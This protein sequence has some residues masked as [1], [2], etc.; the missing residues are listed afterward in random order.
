MFFSFQVLKEARHLLPALPAIGVV[1]AVLLIHAWRPLSR[2][3]RL[4][5]ITVGFAFPGYLFAAYSF[6]TPYVPR[7]DLQL[8]PFTVMKRDL[9]LASLQLMPTYT[10]PANPVYW[11]TREIIAVIAADA[12]NRAGRFPSVRAVGEHPYLSGLNLVYQSNLD[13]TPIFSHGPFVHEDPARFSYSVVIC[14]PEKRYGP[15]DV[16]EPEAA[17]ALADPQ[18]GFHEIGRVPLPSQC[19]AV[20][21]RNDRMIERH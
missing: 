1:L 12:A 11:P 5:L 18:N 10:F 3:F 2:A 17:A 8:G 7:Y 14:G 15:L 16:R 13:G 21:Y 6:D 19:D 9:E 20:I 4:A